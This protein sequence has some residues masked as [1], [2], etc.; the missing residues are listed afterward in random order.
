MNEVEVDYYTTP[1]PFTKLTTDQTA[2][3]RELAIGPV[4]LCRTAQTL[5]ISPPDAAAA[6]VPDVVIESIADLPDLLGLR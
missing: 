5:L 3:I 2:M 4:D 1:G 6:G